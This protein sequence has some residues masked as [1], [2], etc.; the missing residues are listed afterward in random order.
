MIKRK[1]H[2]SIIPNHLNFPYVWSLESISYC[3]DISKLPFNQIHEWILYYDEQKQ[4]AYWNF[5]TLNYNQQIELKLDHSYFTVIAC[6]EISVSSNKVVY[7]NNKG[8]ISEQNA[9]ANK[10]LPITIYDMLISDHRNMFQ[11]A[12]KQK[13]YDNSLVLNSFTMNVVAPFISLFCGN[14]FSVLF[15]ANL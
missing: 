15:D 1:K 7:W 11:Y 10:C 14:Y 9:S 3:N 13:Q 4:I 12:A 5:S 6:G 2:I 8:F